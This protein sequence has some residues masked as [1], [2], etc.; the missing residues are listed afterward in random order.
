MSE[1]G[2]R[3]KIVDAFMALL[4]ERR[5]EEIGFGDVA[6]KAEVP[7][8]RCRAEFNS[9]FSVFAAH[10]ARIDKTVLEGI[11]ADMAQESPRERLFDIMMRRFEA[12][13]PHKAA[14]RSLVRSARCNPPLALALNG[15]TARS[16]QW[17]LTAANIS[18]HGLR[19][20]VRAQG[21]ALLYADVLRTWLHDDDP[22]LAR[23]L[24]AL[25]R[26]LG[27]GQQLSHCLDRLCRVVPSPF[28]GRRRWQPRDHSN[29][30]GEQPAV[31]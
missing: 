26:A 24:A 6:A 25:D 8:A 18:T 19:G 9:L 10:V 16:Q 28:R 27:R 3:D 31:I 7:L 23:T 11:D 12:L 21:L 2:D 4:A 1:K 29:D 22:G 13:A 14:M 20:M 17:M 30:P 15:I 5:F